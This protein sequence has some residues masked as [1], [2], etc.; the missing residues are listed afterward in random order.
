MNTTVKTVVWATCFV[1]MGVAVL[2]ASPNR[3]EGQLARPFTHGP[4]I[5]FFRIY[6]TEIVDADTGETE[7]DQNF[8]VLAAGAGY[9]FNFNFAPGSDGTVRWFTIGIPLFL[10]I[11]GSKRLTFAA[12]L[13]VGTFNNL[14]SIGLS[15]NLFD[16]RGE[17]MEDGGL[18]G[19]EEFPFP[20]AVLVNFGFNL[21]GGDPAPPSTPSAGP[22]EEVSPPN[23]WDPF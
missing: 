11:D 15:Y 19:G 5:Q 22:G 23:Y 8:S 18:A 21:G 1:A 7:T 17:G 2:L 12:G 16:V 10:S 14:L 6:F 3:A 9:S 20:L 13:T 4:T